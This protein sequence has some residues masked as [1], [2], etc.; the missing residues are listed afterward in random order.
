MPLRGA[1]I[2]RKERIYAFPKVMYA[3]MT[4]SGVATSKSDVA[5]NNE[6]LTVTLPSW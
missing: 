5:R 6:Q 2:L 1:P 3:A 4:K